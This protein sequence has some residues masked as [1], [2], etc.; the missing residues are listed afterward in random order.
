MADIGLN[1]AIVLVVLAI[2]AYHFIIFP[3]LVSPLAKVP[4]AH[5]SAPFSPAW[6]LWKRYSYKE[7]STIHKAHQK[8]GPIIRLGPSEVSINCVQGGI[9]KVYQ[10]G[11]EKHAWYSNLFD[12]YG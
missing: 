9:L 4:N 5:W 6:I 7:V 1:G 8:L 11:F 3:Y 2:S 10:G 12:N